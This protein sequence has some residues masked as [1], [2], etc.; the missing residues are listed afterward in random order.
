MG[1]GTCLAL[2]EHGR[3]V[4][5]WDIQADAA[6]AT[7]AEC[8]ERF[9]VPTDVQVVDLADAAGLEKAVPGTL[10]TLGGVGGLAYC[11]GVNAWDE[12]PHDVGQTGWEHVM[13]VN[14]RGAAI[15]TRW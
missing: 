3:P 8:A 4:S 11:A 14:L 1:Y 15:L 10:K 7:A 13:G 2:A 6:E 12:G 9:G 5:V